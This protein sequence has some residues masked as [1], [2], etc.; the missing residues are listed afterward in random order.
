MMPI[1][2]AEYRASNKAVHNVLRL[3]EFI[4]LNPGSFVKRKCTSSP[5]QEKIDLSMGAIQSH[6]F[7][8]KLV[9]LIFKIFKES[10]KSGS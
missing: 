6:T 3:R 8:P 1:L 9:Q 7:F 10:L 4:I 2:A 5:N